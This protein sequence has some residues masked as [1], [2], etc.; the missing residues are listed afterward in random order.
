MKVTKQATTKASFP[1]LSGS[2]QNTK[3]IMMWI[4]KTHFF[5]LNRLNFRFQSIHSVSPVV[6]SCL[7]W[8]YTRSMLTIPGIIKVKYPLASFR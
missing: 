8:Q 2:K 1:T 5:T 4:A 6:Y 7:F 3:A